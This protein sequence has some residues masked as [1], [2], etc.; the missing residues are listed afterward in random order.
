MERSD[1]AGDTGPLNSYQSSL[2]VE[3]VSPPTVEASSLP[4]SDG[5][6]SALP[7]ESVMVSP[8]ALAM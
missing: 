6:N 2:L 5:I 7:D 1:G 3:E 4:P 8:E